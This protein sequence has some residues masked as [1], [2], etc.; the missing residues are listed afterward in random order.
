ME[1]NS[2]KET[3]IDYCLN[4]LKRDDI[5]NELKQL[6]RPMMDVVLQEIYPYIFLSMIFV[7]IS[8]LLILA[9]FILLLRYK[10]NTSIMKKS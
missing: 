5:K 9:I 6:M 8:F 1:N 3:V 4:V 10:I 7:F 2:L